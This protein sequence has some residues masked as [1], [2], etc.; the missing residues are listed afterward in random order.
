MTL[1]I[2]D[3]YALNDIRVSKPIT[4]YALG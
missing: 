3:E 4:T 2:Q 1:G